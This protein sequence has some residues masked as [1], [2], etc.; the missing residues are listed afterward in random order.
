MH[1]KIEKWIKYE[2]WSFWLFYGPLTP[3]F[4]YKIIKSGAPA[5]FC[6]AN[7]G[8][9]WGGFMNYSKIDLIN[10][11]DEQYKPKTLFYSSYNN[12]KIPLDFP[13]I[14]KPNTGERGIGVE[15]IR[16][17]SDFNN[18]LNQHDNSDLILQE[19]IN[20]P[21]EFGVFYV[22]LPKETKGKIISI[23]AKDFLTI[24]GDGKQSLK[25]LIENNLRAFYRKEYLFDR[26]K[27]DLNSILEKGQQIL[28]EPIGNH[29]RGTT[30]LDGSNLRTSILEEKIDAIAQKV[31]GFFYGRIDLK[32]KNLE[33]FQNGK[34]VILEING[35]NS[36]AT[37]IYDPNF[38]LIKAY[39]EVL[40]HLNYQY[41]IAV[42]NHELGQEWTDWKL[43]AKEITS[44]YKS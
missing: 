29:S 15:L 5:Y 42:Q 14:V 32:A 43:L 25:E 37:H 23:T 22:R 36:E 13:F 12:E 39:K 33:D 18:Y 40:R 11:I 19:Y 4:I 10:Q 20:Y 7:P 2:F 30:F 34:F 44:R 17:N 35:V 1:P 16:N 26:Y 8:I 27:N 41:K 31:D 6:S 38:N 24:I 9:K 28:L 3:W 21:L